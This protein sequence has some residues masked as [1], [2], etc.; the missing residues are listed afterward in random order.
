MTNHWVDIRNAD[1]ILSIGGNSAEA[2]PVGFRWVM[3]A[4][5]RNNAILISIDPRYNRTTAVADYHAWLRTGTDIVW[6]GGLINYLIET[7]RYNHEYVLAYTD[8]AL[9]VKEGFGFTDGL[10]TGYDREAHTYDRSTWNYELDEQGYIRT[11]ESLQHPRCVFQL[12]RQHFSRYTLDQVENISGMK[13]ETTLKLWELIAQ[14]AAPDKTMTILYALGWTQH[15]IGSQMIRTGAMVQLLLGNVGMPGGGVNALR[16]HSNIQGLTDVGLLSNLLPGYLNLPSVNLQS[17]ADYMKTRIKPPLLQ[18]E[19]S[20]WKF[21]ERFFVSLMKDWYGDVATAENNW[22]YD[23]LPKLSEPIYDVLYAVNDMVKGRMTGAF[24]QGFNVLAAFPHKAKVVEGLSKLK[25]FVIMDPLAVE[26]GEFWK[27]YGEFN[28]VDPSKIGTEVFRLPT[29]CFAEDDG[30]ITNSARWLQ[31][32]EKAAPPPGESLADTEIIGRLMLR[33]K[34][35][36]KAEGGAFPDPILNLTWN[37]AN[38]SYPSASE[39]AREYN[40]R[41]LADIRDE[42]GNLLRREGELLDDFSQLR[43]DGTTACGCWIYSGA[44][45]E[46][47]NMMARRDNSDPFDLGVTLGW[48]WAWPMNRRLLYNRA[49]ARPDGTPWAP[50][51]AFIWWDGARWVGADVP[52]YPVATPPSAGVGPFIVTQTGGGHFFASEWLNEGPFPEHYEPMESPIDRNPLHPDN[53]LAF[54]NPIA[55]VFPE[56]RG[57]FGANTEF[58]YAATSYRLTE[59]FHYWTTHARLNAIAQPEK[60]VEIGEVLAQELGIRAGERVRVRSKRGHIDAVAVVTKRMVPLTVDGRTVHQIGIP[61]HWGYKGVARKAHLT[62]TLTPFVGD[63]NT[64]TPEFKSFLVNVEK[65]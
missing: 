9:L 13:K 35:L 30:S 8:A 37:Y 26:T 22:C 5:A 15:T 29:T 46:Q 20:Y 11:D 42:Q 14:T 2:H 16:G 49:S 4:K 25:F 6:L 1:V 54:H 53:P 7:G 55:R 59:H 44:W 19:V 17:Y 58:P 56:D 40:G 61:L 41:A 52:D 43:A 65:L 31:W 64:Q 63:G 60:F 27:N 18:G 23:W 34:A 50:N 33:I 45:T 12:M 24:C 36:Y 32:H 21:Y 48:A 39:L 51:K 28:D 3:D 10:F 47:G 57:N 38:P 62:N